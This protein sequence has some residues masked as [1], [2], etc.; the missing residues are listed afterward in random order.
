MHG[1]RSLEPELLPFK[2]EIDR[3]CRDIRS[4]L[5]LEMCSQLSLRGQVPAV[6]EPPRL[7]REFFIPK[8]YDRGAGVMGPQIAESVMLSEETSSILLRRMPAK[9]EDPGA[10]IIQCIIGHI[11]I[12]RIIRFGGQCECATRIL[13]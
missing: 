4:R 2:P 3:F 13:L 11:R 5:S 7:F 12:E 6:E 1:R 9:L 10:K 8:R